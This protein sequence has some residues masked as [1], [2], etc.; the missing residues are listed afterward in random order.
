[1]KLITRINE[2]ISIWAN[3]HQYVVRIKK[4]PN[5][6]EK[7]GEIW[8]LPTLDSCFTEIFDY[9]CKERLAD[10]RNKN[11]KEIAEIILE[12][13]KEIL[14]ILEPFVNLKSAQT[15]DLKSRQTT[16]EG[17]EKPYSL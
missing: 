7:H 10:D 5:Q 8:Y 12:T 1:M 3:T 17:G 4:N 2:K 6:R 11:L 15:T 13:K 14:K 16:V 9:L